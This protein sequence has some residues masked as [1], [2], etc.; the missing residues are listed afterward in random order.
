M[1]D[2]TFVYQ[3]KAKSPT[4]RANLNVITLI[5]T[6]VSINKKNSFRTQKSGALSDFHDTG[7]TIFCIN[8]N[9]ITA[10]RY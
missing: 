10:I 7:K 6:T 4:K 3:C 9:Y 5:L 2:M 8:R 1:N